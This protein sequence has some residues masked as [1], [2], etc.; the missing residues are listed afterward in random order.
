MLR[1]F[2]SF[3]GIGAFT[4]ALKNLEI[5]YQLV[6]FSEIDKYAV[7]S[8]CAIHDVSEELNYGDIT[9]I[10]VEELPDFDLFTFGFPCFREGTL[11]TT[12]RGLVPIEEITKNDYVLTHKN[13]F[14]KVVKTMK[15]VKSGIYHLRIQGSPHTFVTEEHPYYV[16]RVK[17]VWD[18]KK[19]TNVREFSE[20]MWVDV[21]DLKK[22][23]LVGFSTNCN[24]EN[25]LGLS[26]EDCWLL[27]R[28]IADGYI[29]DGKRANRINSYNHKV[30]FCIGKKKLK[31]FTDK[32][33]YYKFGISEEKTVYKA[34]II[35]EH[36]LRLCKACGSGAANK[37]IPQ[38]ILDLPKDLLENFL[39]GYMSGDGSEKNNVFK[40]TS[41]SKKLV[42]QLGQ[43]VQKVY[44]TP[45]CIF[46]TK[47][48][49]TAIIEGREVNQKDTWQIQFKKETR[50]QNKAVFIDGMLWCPVKEIEIDLDFS[51]Y[52][53]NMEVENDNSY[54]AN[55]CTVHNC[56]SFSVAGKGLG[57]SDPRGTLFFEAYK[58]LEAKLPRYFIFENVKG[59]LSHDKGNTI[60]TI[61]EYLGK[62][63]YEITMD[64]LNT[65]D[66]GLP[67]NRERLFCIGRRV[68]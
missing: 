53:Y 1:V 11:I 30:T 64:L 39:D 54:V 43:V 24:S 60:H 37:V 36:F 38:F 42:Y 27:G 13:R 18:S 47:R 35:D 65:K 15:Q 41:V 6:G 19:R 52:V 16:R 40:A 62:L 5:D 56:Q 20:P 8:F 32:V 28:Y 22:G 50:K 25:S 14:Q 45:Y 67:Q 23:D 3:A 12:K 46:F 2:E 4:K 51:G 49:R 33:Q 55:N 68:E 61:M 17:R 63:N 7:K 10:K 29:Q 31:Q 59:L 21:K 57:F 48:P 26:E 66:Y 58:I 34:R 44:N 9:K